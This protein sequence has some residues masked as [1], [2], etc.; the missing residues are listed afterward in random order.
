M[1]LTLTFDIE[2]VPDVA[3]L[4]QVHG[5]PDALSDSEVAE[6]A[7]QRQRA[8]NG[9]DF[10][11]HHLHR[12]VTISCALRS[13]DG[14]RV[15]SMAAPKASEAEIIQRFFDGIE[16]LFL[17]EFFYNFFCHKFFNGWKSSHNS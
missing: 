12:V 10:L 3:G 15:W 16:K 11:P 5:L 7:Y 17:C 6:L 9:S 4:R 1:I 13:D 2:T 8:K 14:F